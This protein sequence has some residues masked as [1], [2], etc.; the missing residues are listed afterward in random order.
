MYS[1]TA[2]IWNTWGVFLGIFFSL[3]MAR[4]GC[5]RLKGGHS[6]SGEQEPVL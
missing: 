3:S 2:G 4:F 5:W 6:P 1:I